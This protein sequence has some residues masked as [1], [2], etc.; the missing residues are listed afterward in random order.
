MEAKIS[1]YG[2]PRTVALLVLF[3]QM[4]SSLLKLQASVRVR[5][6]KGLAI[7]VP[8]LTLVRNPA[9]ARARLAL[10][11]CGALTEDSVWG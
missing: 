10:A 2:E 3:D 7:D 4:S 11:L 9:E 6:Q 1:S 8:V 5:G